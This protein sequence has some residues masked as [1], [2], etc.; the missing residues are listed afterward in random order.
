MT[1]T[2][3]GSGGNIGGPQQPLQRELETTAW[4]DVNKM[5]LAIVKDSIDLS[6]TEM[7][8]NVKRH[9]TE[10]GRPT[11]HPMLN[12][13]TASGGI[14]E[15]D[16]S[17]LPHY[18]ELLDL[19]PADLKEQLAEDQA[20]PF[21][22]RHPLLVC[23][24][25]LLKAL[26]KAAAWL[27]VAISP[28]DVA[29]LAA[30]RTRLNLA[31]PF[32]M[33]KTSMTMGDTILAE[34]RNFLTSVGPNHPQFDRLNN[35][36]S[37]LDEA[38]E[39]LRGIYGE[40]EEG[41]IDII[42]SEEFAAFAEALE[43]LNTFYHSTELS[44]DLRILSPLLKTL[45]A[46][47]SAFSLGIGSPSLFLGL[48]IAGVGFNSSESEAGIVGESLEKM[49]NTLIGAIIPDGRVGD[50]T[51]L[52]LLTTTSLIA[53]IAFAQ[54]IGDVG[55]GRYPTLDR[56]DGERFSLDLLLHLG[57]N[58]GLIHDLFA[59]VATASGL[60]GNDHTIATESLA[61]TA[62]LLIILG[63]AETDHHTAEELLTSL[64]PHLL[65]STETLEGFAED[66]PELGLF[67]QQAKMALEEDNIA[68]FVEALGSAL[69]LIG[70]SMDQLTEDLQELHGFATLMYGALT[71]GTDDLT[72]TGTII[73]IV[74]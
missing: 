71:T 26:A 21:E 29:S 20:L 65:S 2:G 48:M 46:I 24:D 72:N 51:M 12:L 18:E 61:T 58:L 73:S 17:W 45:T 14:T 43:E 23:L 68:G 37:Q 50:R 38:L 1:V 7:G 8:G 30:A 6:F 52:T 41:N 55:I 15:E 5:L 49:V 32:M 44:Q 39:E 27:E 35:V 9:H 53:L 25:N 16:Q 22:S 28:V 57:S 31:L 36:I 40:M 70:I 56:A 63:A 64:R 60:T 54:V 62:M 42:K 34:A 19:L 59:H 47:T 4:T 69:A 13:R 74:A 66:I 3:S 11:L 10:P 33:L 67:L